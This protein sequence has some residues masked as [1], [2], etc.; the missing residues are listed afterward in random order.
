MKQQLSA[1]DKIIENDISRYKSNT[2]ASTPIYLALVFEFLYFLCVYGQQSGNIGA[3]FA[4]STMGST[5]VYTYMM[6]ISVILNLVLLLGG[7]LAS[8]ELKNYNKMYSYIAWVMAVI[9]IVRIFIYPMQVYGSE[10]ST[11]G[12]IFATYSFVFMIIWL[13]LSALCF[14]AAGTFGF[15]GSIKREKFNKQVDGGEIDLEAAY[16]EGEVL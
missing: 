7:F 1:N 11:G 3:T 13:V 2:K 6:G 14:A 16:K 12:T 9:Q 15:I 4:E 8:Q 5:D 10:L